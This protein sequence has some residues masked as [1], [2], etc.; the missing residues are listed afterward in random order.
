MDS[1]RVSTG[2]YTKHRFL[3]VNAIM[4]RYITG[5]GKGKGTVRGTFLLAGQRKQRRPGRLVAPPS[6][7]Y[8]SLY[9]PQNLTTST[10]RAT[11]LERLDSP[12]IVALVCQIFSPYS[13]SSTP[14]VWKTL[15]FYKRNSSMLISTSKSL[16]TYVANTM[17]VLFLT[18]PYEWWETASNQVVSYELIRN[19]LYS[20]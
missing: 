14:F 2:R 17:Y 7:L 19:V 6:L 8:S 15:N 18:P 10:P 12:S 13:T 20:T 11:G 4:A 1:A 9:T 3:G 16:N 5:L